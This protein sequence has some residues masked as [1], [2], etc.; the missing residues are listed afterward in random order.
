[1]MKTLFNPQ[2]GVSFGGFIMVLAVL[3][4]AAIFGMKLIPAYMEN[5]KIQKAFDAIVQDPG[6]QAGSIADI[7]MSFFNRAITMDNVTNVKMEDIEISKDD[8]KL[9]ISAAYKV[10]IPFAGNVSLLIEFNPKAS[11]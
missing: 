7:R 1:M 4:V 3:I 2:R 10:K 11:K 9:E 5:G 8:G 6:L